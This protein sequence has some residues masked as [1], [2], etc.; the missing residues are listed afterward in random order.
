[1]RFTDKLIPRRVID[2]PF[3]KSPNGLFPDTDH[4]VTDDALFIKQKNFDLYIKESEGCFPKISKVENRTGTRPDKIHRN[5]RF[6]YWYREHISY[7]EQ[8]GQDVLSGPF[9]GCYLAAFSKNGWRYV[10]HIGTSKRTDSNRAVR[11]AWNQFRRR[12]GV[13]DVYGFNPYDAY[14]DIWRRLPCNVKVWGGISADNKLYAVLLQPFENKF[15]GKYEILE[16]KEVRSVF[17]RNLGNI[18]DVP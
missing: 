5:F 16:V 15:D 7:V 11:N 6:L 17:W 12:E 3:L 2:F 10:A 1:M 18:T 4:T 8:D 13:F 9:S 14:K